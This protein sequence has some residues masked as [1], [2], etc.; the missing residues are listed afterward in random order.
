[1]Q[2]PQSDLVRLNSPDWDKN[3]AVYLDQSTSEDADTDMTKI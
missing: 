1:M 2:G 3:P